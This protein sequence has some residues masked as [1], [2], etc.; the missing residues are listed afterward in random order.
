MEEKN[1]SCEQSKNKT[2]E[3]NSRRKFLKIAAVTAGGFALVA[4]MNGVVRVPFLGNGQDA[5]AGPLVAAAPVP[6]EGLAPFRRSV[7]DSS[8]TYAQY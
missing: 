3:N 8:S 4:T 2:K 6:P 7:G 5:S 1:E